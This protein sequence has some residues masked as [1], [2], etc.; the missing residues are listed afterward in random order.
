ML[1]PPPRDHQDPGINHA[2]PALASQFFTTESPR[3]SGWNKIKNAFSTFVLSVYIQPEKNHDVVER[4]WPLEIVKGVFESCFLP[5]DT[6]VCIKI[7]RI[8]L[9]LEFKSIC[10]WNIFWSGNNLSSS[11]IIHQSVYIRLLEMPKCVF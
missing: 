9:M 10:Q 4:T 2:S 3:Q 7:L 6:C 11:Y 1:F 5:S 8:F